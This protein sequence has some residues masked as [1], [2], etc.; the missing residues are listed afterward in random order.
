MTNI[1]L[2][3]TIDVGTNIVHY[4]PLELAIST[5]RQSHT[6]I[7]PTYILLLR[8]AFAAVLGA[9]IGLERTYRDKDAGIRTHFLVALGSALFFV[10]SR[11]GF[12]GD[13]DPGRVAAQIVSGIGF[14]GA[15]MIIMQKHTIHGLTTAAGMWV[16]A[17]IG[18]ACGAGLYMVAL[19]ATVLSLL[20][21]EVVGKLGSK[22]RPQKSNRVEEEDNDE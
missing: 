19:T 21:L 13:G 8:L 3:T 18:M 9:A 14:L 10:I 16:A 20:G 6:E 22:V 7:V 1:V 5:I 15:G 11:H 17:G 4:V 2:Q 12:G